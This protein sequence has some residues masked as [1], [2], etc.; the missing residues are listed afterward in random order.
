MSGLRVRRGGTGGPLLVLL[1]GLGATAEVWDG[2]AA[3]WPGRWLAPDLPGH[4]GSARLPRYSFGH[5][6][7]AV[8]DLLPADEP[9]VVC[10]HSLGGVVAL[11]LAAG[12]FGPTPRAAVGL[13]IKVRWTEEELARAAAL[14]GRV[15]PVYPAREA[16]ADRHLKVA[17]LSGLVAPELVPESALVQR[18]EGWTLALDP[19]AFGVGAP[20]MPG[21]LAAA[22][23]PVLLAAGERDPMSGAADLRAL[24]EAPV[25]LAGLGHNAQVEGP[26]AVVSLAAR[27]IA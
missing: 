3:R 12:W 6:A 10:G 14:A 22:R 27:F 25:I 5:L 2:V 18:A 23:C 21:L 13:G 20:A 11:A 1:H 8:A 4:G 7:A 17:G 19:A 26:D 16:A 24:V 9:A 15:H